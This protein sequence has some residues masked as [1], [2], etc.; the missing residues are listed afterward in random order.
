MG[1]TGLVEPLSNVTLTKDFYIGKYEI[2]QTQWLKVCTGWWPGAAPDATYDVGDNYP[3]CF[4]PGSVTGQVK[5][6]IYTNS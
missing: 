5:T 2:T 4:F 6:E 1:Q 3:A